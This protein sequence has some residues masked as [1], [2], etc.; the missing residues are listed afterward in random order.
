MKKVFTFIS[1]LILTLILWVPAQSQQSYRNIGNGPV[2][3]YKLNPAQS[4]QQSS[5]RVTFL[6]DGFE[7]GFDNLG[8]V[9]T[10]VDGDG[11]N[12]FT[13]DYFTPRTGTYCAA[14]H[15][16]VGGTIL[17]PDNWLATPPIDLTS[18]TGAVLLEYWVRAQD[19]VWPSEHYAV[20]VSTTGD[21]PDDF[22]GADGSKLYEETVVAGNDVA[23]NL[24]VKRTI[25]LSAYAGELV[26]LAFRHFDSS[27]WFALNIDDVIVYE[28]STVD[29]GITGVVA[30][31]NA[32]NCMLTDDEPVT[33]TLFNYGG[34]PQ[35]GFDVSYT[36]NGT[37]VTETVDGVVPPAGSLDYTFAQNANFSAMG[38]FEMRF[39]VMVDGDIDAANNLFNYNIDN[40]DANIEVVVETDS[41]AGQAWRITNSAGELIAEHG[42]YQWNIT[43]TTKV[44]V[45]ADDCYQL[46][47]VSPSGSSNTVSIFYNGELVSTQE[48]SGNF[49]QYS[50][51]GAC[52]AVSVIYQGVLIPEYGILGN[53]NFSG[54]FLNVGTDAV[55][56]FDVQYTV[57]GMASDVATVSGVNVP[58]GES[59]VFTHPTP[60]EFTELGMQD[61]TLSISNV[62]GEHTPDPNEYTQTVN[63]LNYAPTTRILGEEATGTWCG[64]CV[65]G[66]VFMEYMAAAYPDTWIGV[67]V[68]NQDPMVVSAYDEGIGQFIGG[69]PS[70]LVN[71]YDFS[72]GD[73]IYDVD[74]SQF[75]EAYDIL[76][77]R[78]VPADVT[79]SGATY[80]EASNR[81]SFNVN[82][83]FAGNI[84]GDFNINAI[85][86][87]NDVRGTGDGWDQ[88]NYYSGGGNG[89]MGGY[90]NLPDP[91]PAG[92]MVYENVARAILGG[93]NG[94]AGQI[95]DATPDEP[96]SYSFSYTIPADE[97]M[98]NMYLIGVVSN[99]AT[100]EIINANKVSFETA[101]KVQNISSLV[102]FN[103]F[104]NPSANEFNIEL[105][106]DNPEKISLYVTDFM[107]RVVDSIVDEKEIDQ[108]RTTVNLENLT[109]GVYFVNVKTAN[110]INVQKIVKL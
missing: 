55:T 47:W 33:V 69:Y 45:L 18:A 43:E 46:E 31:S 82:A 71:R 84:P 86:I 15:S 109:P 35:T 94:V 100:G 25:D 50:I 105:N 40:T 54:S 107:G 78:V 89:A 83:L 7:G 8:W 19:Q 16:W 44:C 29:L 62:N 11:E 24:Y 110:S 32:D 95:S 13:P 99:A 36:L 26:F 91:V 27:D 22:T 48:A 104:P 81:V 17:T 21:T 93:W 68:H 5:P 4:V 57:N 14:S 63:I 20:Y 70:G 38:Y 90:E 51:G 108:Y 10:D 75:E 39:E 23:N 101:V 52:P 1:T 98:D 85:I 12:W 76:I 34:A 102:D 3:D 66:H 87:E 49:T 2:V 41:Q 73:N 103:V 59:Y 56:S 88:V 96:Y 106:L 80:D 64:W 61:V 74:P 37:T 30:P 77:D 72:R 65:R 53:N 79:I 60:Y 67:A 92:D 97:N 9:V 28:S 6:E 58:Q 42:A